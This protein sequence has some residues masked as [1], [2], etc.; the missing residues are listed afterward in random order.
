MSGR[1]ATGV[2]LSVRQCRRGSRSSMATEAR[3]L[4]RPT[5]NVFLNAMERADDKSDWVEKMSP[6]ERALVRALVRCLVSELAAK[7]PSH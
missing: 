2:A 7:L 3:R 5:R 1:D 6:I 4:K